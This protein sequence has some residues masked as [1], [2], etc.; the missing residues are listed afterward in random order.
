MFGCVLSCIASSGMT[1]EK[2]NQ[3]EDEQGMKDVKKVVDGL[4]DKRH[5][6]MTDNFF[7]NV[8][9]CHDIGA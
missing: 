7:T 2:S 5:M 6:C 8:E 4:I 1:C 9:L 3:S